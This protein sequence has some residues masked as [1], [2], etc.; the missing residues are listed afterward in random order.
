MQHRDGRMKKDT[1]QPFCGLISGAR[2][3][4]VTTTSRDIRRIFFSGGYK[5][6]FP[7]KLLVP[8]GLLGD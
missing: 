6:S 3:G 5:P 1:R 2:G 4:R 8:L 7:Q